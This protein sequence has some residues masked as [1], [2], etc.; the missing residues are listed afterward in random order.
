VAA[1][2]SFGGAFVGAS[3][4]RD[5]IHMLGITEAQMVNSVN[6]GVTINAGAKVHTVQEAM[7]AS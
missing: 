1:P 6:S 3:P 4:M 2:R 7:V 5:A